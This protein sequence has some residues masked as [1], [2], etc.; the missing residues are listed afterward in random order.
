M[1]PLSRTDKTLPST[2]R[3]MTPFRRNPVRIFGRQRGK[4][5]IGPKPAA[6]GA[7]RPLG[8]KQGVGAGF[9]ADAGRDARLTLL[10]QGLLHGL[11]GTRQEGEGDE[12]AVA[13]R[14]GPEL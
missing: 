8:R 7:G 3:E 2:K 4:I 13:V 12:T 6:G 10:Q 11:L 5:G 9:V 14:V 1:P